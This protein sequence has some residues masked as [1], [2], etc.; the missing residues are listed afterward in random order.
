MRRASIPAAGY[1]RSYTHPPGPPFPDQP[2]APGAGCYGA[3]DAMDL[4][5]ASGTGW[6]K[7]GGVDFPVEAQLGA[8]RRTFG[9][10]G[11]DRR[12]GWNEKTGFFL[13]GSSYR[14]LDS[15]KPQLKRRMLGVGP[16]LGPGLVLACAREAVP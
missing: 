11:D 10:T 16:P 15:W 7:T 3:G 14:L 1:L 12:E 6:K 5:R 8:Q 9:K 4:S 2:T 13:V